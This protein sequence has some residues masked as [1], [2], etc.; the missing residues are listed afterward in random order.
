[1]ETARDAIL[2]AFVRLERRTGRDVFELREIVQEVISHTRAFRETTIRTYVTSVL[3]ANAPVH[4]ANHRN[5]LVRVG[6][7]RYR[8]ITPKD[9]IGSP[10]RRSSSGPPRGPRGDRSTRIEARSEALIVSFR[11]S[12]AEFARTRPFTGPS[13][14]FHR[15]AIDRRRQLGEVGVAVRDELMVEL[16]YAT[17]TAWGMH[18]MGPN[19][20]K[21][22]EYDA[23]TDALRRQ[24]DSLARLQ[25][26]R[27]EELD[28]TR[29]SEVAD[30]L[31][32][33]IVDL[34]VSATGSQLVAGSKTLHHF[35]PDLV[36]PIDRQYTGRFF[37]GASGQVWSMGERSA[38][39]QLFPELVRIG[40]SCNREIEE[41]LS[42]H[43]SYMGT[44]VTKVIDNAIVG[45]VLAP[46]RDVTAGGARRL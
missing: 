2:A 15:R 14:H 8:R 28:P 37:F 19:G 30:D 21:L 3:C 42:R 11:A 45:F 25:R 26:N 43:D 36:P 41:Y 31:W 44:S 9:D 29:A 13:L 24:A 34:S 10:E 40:R 23:F 6:R 32:Q 18:R 20:A 1:M 22:V 38:F 7:G 33:I 27:I 12:L 46:R 17:L 39:T 5:D 16:V 35:L 4:H